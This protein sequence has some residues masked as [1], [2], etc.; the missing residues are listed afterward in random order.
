M[1]SYDNLGKKRLQTY[2][3]MVL[4]RQPQNP[5]NQQNKKKK[6]KN[7]TYKGNL[8]EEITNEIGID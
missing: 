6:K 3:L 5:T 4:S 2:K 7:K 8:A 1:R